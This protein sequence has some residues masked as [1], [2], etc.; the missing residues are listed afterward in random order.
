MSSWRKKGYEICVVKGREHTP[1]KAN[2]RQREH[3]LQD[4]EM[5]N[6]ASFKLFLYS[7]SMDIG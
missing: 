1:G 6:I 5:G 4:V 3:C 7:V 2:S